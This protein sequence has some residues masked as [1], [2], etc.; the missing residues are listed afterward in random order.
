MMDDDD[1]DII[2][3]YIPLLPTYMFVYVVQKEKTILQ[4]ERFQ[5]NPVYVVPSPVFSSQHVN[6]KKRT[7]E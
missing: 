2:I 6:M 3:M 1:D 7:R 5:S 4:Y